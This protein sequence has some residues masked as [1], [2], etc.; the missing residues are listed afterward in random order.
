MVDK[1]DREAR[2][3]HGL[4]AQGVFQFGNRNPRGVEIASVRRETDPRA[5]VAHADFTADG[6]IAGLFAVAEVHVVD[7]AAAFDLDFQVAGQGVDDGYADAMQAAGKAIAA[8]GKFRAGVEPRE[9]KFD[10][11]DAFLGMH[12]DGHAAA[13]VTDFDRTVAMQADVDFRGMAGEGFVNAV[14]DDF[15]H[16]MVGPRNVG[17]H[18]RTFS[19]RVQSSQHFDGGGVVSTSHFLLFHKGKFRMMN[20]RFIARALLF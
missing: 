1:V 15:L 19:D 3:K 9:D 18:A 8:V 11:A 14:V 6:E 2:A 16:Q 7:L 17:I 12:V 5:G 13:V 4:G 10:P 20:Y